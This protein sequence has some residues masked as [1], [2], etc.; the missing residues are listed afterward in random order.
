VIYFL[1]NAHILTFSDAA[2]CSN[3]IAVNITKPEFSVISIYDGQPP[4]TVFQ[5]LR[6][7][8]EVGEVQFMR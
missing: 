3:S 6:P 4:I 2:V 8:G 7:D 5:E 1:K